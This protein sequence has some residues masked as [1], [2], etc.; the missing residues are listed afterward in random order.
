VVGR[1]RWWGGRGGGEAEVVALAIGGRGNER[2]GR[3]LHRLEQAVRAAVALPAL[4]RPKSSPIA[5]TAAQPSASTGQT[6]SLTFHTAL[7]FEL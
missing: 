1:Q 5:N 7:S 2:R 4:V 6:A 3:Q